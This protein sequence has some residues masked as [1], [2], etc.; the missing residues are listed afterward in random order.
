MS[1]TH[2]IGQASATNLNA[3]NGIDMQLAKSAGTTRYLRVLLAAVVFIPIV[4]ITAVSSLSY[5]AAFQ[6]A[7]DRVSRAADAIREYALKI[8]ETD[9]LVLDHIA[10]HASGMDW[11]ELVRSED[12]HRYLQQFGSKPQV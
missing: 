9:E 4:L 5:K 1:R 11:S 7:H 12:F 10:E 3:A 8:F 6:D 2:S